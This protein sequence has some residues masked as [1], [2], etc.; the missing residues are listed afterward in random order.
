MTN[1]YKLYRLPESRFDEDNVLTLCLLCE[2]CLSRKEDN[3]WVK[4]CMAYEVEGSRP[5]WRPKRTWR[6]VVEKNCQARKLNKEDDMDHSSS[7]WRKLIKDVWWC[8]WVWVGKCFFW[9]GLTR[10]APDERLLNS[11][12]CLDQVPLRLMAFFNCWNVAITRGP[13]LHQNTNCYKPFT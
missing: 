1:F 13:H 4:R 12:V 10:V 7:R 9:Y 5:R 11:C 8:G 2:S 6:E 3:N